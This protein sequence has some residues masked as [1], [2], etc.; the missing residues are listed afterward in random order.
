MSEQ[1]LHVALPGININNNNIISNKWTS[2]EQHEQEV[3]CILLNETQ[4]R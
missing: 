3:I 2:M 4:N 1:M